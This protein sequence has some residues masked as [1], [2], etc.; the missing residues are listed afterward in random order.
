MFSAERDC[1]VFMA[2]KITDP[3][4]CCGCTACASSCAHKAIVMTADK[5]GFEYPI[6]NSCLCVEC[7][8]CEKVCPFHDDYDSFGNRPVPEY[9]AVRCLDNVELGKSQSGGAFYLLAREILEQDGVVYGAAFGDGFRVEHQ[10]AETKVDCDRQ[11]GSKY[12][13]SSLLNIF[14]LVRQDLHDCRKVLFCGTPCQVAGLRSFL[15]KRRTQSLTTVDLFCHGVASPLFWDNYLKMIEQS[16][17]SRIDEVRMR[18]KR[19]G[20]LS[21][22]ETYVLE[23][24]KEV[25][26]N[27]F[28]SLYYAGLISRESCFHCPFANERRVGDISIGDYHGWNTYHD[29]F[30][31]NTGMSLVLVNSGNGKSLL[32]AMSVRKDVFCESTDVKDTVHVAL[33]SPAKMSNDYERFWSDFYHRGCKFVCKKYGDMSWRTQL[34]VRL[35]NLF[36]R[37]K[38][39]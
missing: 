4:A 12:V 17:H 7:G 31:D 39:R 11:R 36:C 38:L 37:N 10:R 18:D 25:H 14:S 27:T 29:Q 24:K 19:Y 20:W 6:V 16:K 2:I 3:A 8:L 13:Q 21:S 23:N 34:H 32:E 30:T 15:G 26:K 5:K 9:Y 33:S 35:Y 1:I 28:Y 22:D